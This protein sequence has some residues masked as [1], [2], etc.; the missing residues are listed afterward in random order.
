MNFIPLYE[1]GGNIRCQNTIFSVDRDADRVA[2]A[3]LADLVVRV[4]PVALAVR[5]VLAARVVL[6]DL[7]V[8][9]RVDR[10]GRLRR[11][12]LRVITDRVGRV[13]MVRVVP[14]DLRL[15]HRRHAAAVDADVVL[16]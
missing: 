7:V 11:L 12:R 9:D 4:A 1:T 5:V 16:C 6:A 10:E 2:P 14:V 15:R 3:G 13:A 8:T